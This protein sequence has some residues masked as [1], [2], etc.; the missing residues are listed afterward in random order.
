M[1]DNARL[2]R[3]HALAAAS[4]GMLTTSAAAPLASA[5]PPTAG[6]V[7]SLAELSTAAI[8]LDAAVYLASGARS[9]LFRGKAGAAPTDPLQGIHVSSHTPGLHWERDWDGTHGRPEWFG[10]AVNDGTAGACAAN[11][12]ALTACNALCPVMLLSNADYFLRATWVSAVSNRTIRGIYGTGNDQG[13]GTRVI[14]TGPAAKSATQFVFGVFPPPR[15]RGSAMWYARCEDI[16]FVRDVA[17]APIT[18]PASRTDYNGATG[19]LFGGSISCVMNRVKIME[20]MVGLW[21]NG[22]IHGFIDD[23]IAQRMLHGDGSNPANDTFTGFLLGGPHPTFDVIGANASIYMRRCLATGGGDRI[24]DATGCLLKDYMGDTFLSDFEATLQF[25]I[26]LDCNNL[27][28]IEAAQDI[29][30]IHPVLDAC[31]GA[32]IRVADANSSASIGIV[33]PYLAPSGHGVG[34]LLSNSQ[35]SVTVSGG[36]I[37][38]SPTATGVQAVNSAHF[39]VQGIRIRDCGQPVRLHDSRSFRLAPNIFNASTGSAAAVDLTGKTMQGVV[40]PMVHGAPGMIATGINLSGD[41]IARIDCQLS[42]IGADAVAKGR[43]LYNGKP[44]QAGPFGAGNL[45]SGV[46]G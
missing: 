15:S 23:C 39:D 9:G 10:A 12:A 8:A 27:S 14:L 21:A 5:P 19:V 17:V 32:G 26:R 38:G 29:S 42:A 22:V 36:Q 4:A 46:T 31:Y 3:R 11:L 13:Q 7:H 20:S 18:P 33:D 37:L 34:V 45:A 41:G 25:G 16:A 28:A 35:G 44:V 6:L 30:I 24:L 2:T 1:T 40:A 43:L